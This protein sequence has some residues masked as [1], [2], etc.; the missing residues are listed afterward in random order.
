M[1][2][3]LPFWAQKSRL[4]LFFAQSLNIFHRLALLLGLNLGKYGLRI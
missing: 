4:A 2:R 3:S 1:L